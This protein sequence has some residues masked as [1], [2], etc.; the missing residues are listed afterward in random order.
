VISAL[1]ALVAEF[2]RNLA[3]DLGQYTC[4]QAQR[5]NNNQQ[6]DHM[7]EQPKTTKKP[8]SKS[9]AQISDLKPKKDAKGG[10]GNISLNYGSIK[11]EYK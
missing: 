6:E 1:S 2:P 5:N 11:Y 9:K 4:E 8:K 10:D 7:N 3:A